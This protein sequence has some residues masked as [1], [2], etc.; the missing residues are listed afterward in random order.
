MWEGSWTGGRHG[1]QGGSVRKS[2][3]RKDVERID[4]LKGLVVSSPNVVV[5][6]AVVK[7]MI[8]S[9]KPPVKVVL[10]LVVTNDNNASENSNA[11]TTKSKTSL[12]AT[13]ITKISWTSS[14][15]LE[16]EDLYQ[17][18]HGVE[19]QQQQLDGRSQSRAL[20][21]EEREAVE[22]DL[23]AMGGRVAALLIEIQQNQDGD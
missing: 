13:M 8:L 17:P 10:A 19:Q 1:G 23:N 21:L 12:N 2:L 6:A 22:G 9:A 20:I 5:A 7:T 3:A 11:R 15:K 14:F 18:R 4:R 16:I